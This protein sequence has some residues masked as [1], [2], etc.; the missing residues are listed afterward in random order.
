M[1]IPIAANRAKRCKDTQGGS[2]VFYPFNF[3][4]DAF[5][6]VDGVA[7]AI[8]VA[9]TEVFE[10]K[11]VGDGNIF[12]A[13]L[14][15]DENTGTSLCLQNLVLLLHSIDAASSFELTNMAQSDVSG[16]LKDAN[17]NYHWVA[18]N[19]F[20]TFI[21]DPSTG[22]ARADFNGY[23]VTA[24]A[25]SKELPALLDDATRDAFLLLVSA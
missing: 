16:V 18:K 9:L 6:V 2:L 19:S 25:E 8:N 10:Y 11:L 14:T 24:T 17:N 12:N 20:K 3:I 4:E 15:T 21:A 5:T 1:C 7:T 13:P 22:G 23:T